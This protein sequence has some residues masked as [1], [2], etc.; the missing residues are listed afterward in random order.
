V[1][2]ARAGVADVIRDALGERPSAGIVAGLSVGLQD[3]LSRQQW[4]ELARSGTS[5][6][7]AIS[8]L[9][10]AMVAAIAGWLA[11]QV[12]HWRQRQG[13]T[14]TRRDVAVLCA[15]LTAIAYSA[16]A[17]MSVP[18]QR[19]LVMIGLGAGA[20]LARRR[21]GVA[22]GLAAC[23]GAVVALD[24]LAPLA[25]GF[26][27]SFGAVAAILFATGGYLRKPG[28]L[29]SYLQVQGAVTVGLT[30]ALVGSFG[31]VSLVAVAV[32]LVAIPLYTLV[33]VPA[34]LVSSAVSL[35]SRAVGEPLL[36]ATAWLI[37]FTWPVIAVPASWPMATFAVAGLNPAAWALLCVGTLAALSPLPSQGRAAGI[38]LILAACAW[39]PAPLASGEVRLEVLDVG[40]GLAVL[41]QTRRHTLLY[42]AGPAF[43]SGTDAGQLVVLP[44][45]KARGIRALDRLALS[46]DDDDHKGGAASLLG[47]LPV[48]EV[49]V[50]PQPHAI[51]L[52]GVVPAAALRHCRRGEHWQWDGVAF[53]WL[54]PGERP[55]EQDNDG[56]CVLQIT[57]GEHVILLTGDIEA[58]A[59][60]EFL[61]SWRP[62]PV[63]VVVAP[64]H[65]SLS[66]STAEFVAATAPDWVVFTVGHR[67]RWGFPAPR[68]TARWRAV[69]SKTLET[70]TT[71]A[72][73]F[74]ARPG[75]PLQPPARWRIDHHRFWQD[76]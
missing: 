72:I 4:L 9:H 68:V 13:S 40:Q 61:E 26:W 29:R 55:H 45:L 11:G 20:A 27:L 60:Q 8:G 42:D 76:P 56:S 64:H 59:E 32:N 28:A 33:I 39:R 24:P 53:E 14:G 69:G 38:V 71:G 7:M 12:Q 51:D 49:V 25:P 41:V 2:V 47:S 15:A 19:T 5:H 66:S 50:G 58:A 16:L 48:R 3:A 73:E 34:V 46:H 17:G 63:D 70:S 18:T 31:N 1:L 21:V 54:H 74:V 65:G 57:A 30:P 10:I 6:L 35:A 62:R 23:A 67:N 37:E 43:R 36:L 75:R 52:A 44:C 22:D